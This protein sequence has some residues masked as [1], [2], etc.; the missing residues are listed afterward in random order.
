MCVS[1][2]LFPTALAS[3]DENWEVQRGS[4]LHGGIPGS[5]VGGQAEAKCSPK[6]QFF[7]QQYFS[8]YGDSWLCLEMGARLLQM[9]LMILML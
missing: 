4:L 5:P 9:I 7:Q 6:W 2:A 3:P 1:K 8:P